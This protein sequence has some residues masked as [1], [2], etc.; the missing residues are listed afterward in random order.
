[1]GPNEHRLVV[2]KRSA[3]HFQ[4]VVENGKPQE[5]ITTLIRRMLAE[6]AQQGGPVFDV[7]ERSAGGRKEWNVIPVSARGKDGSF[8]AQAGSWITSCPF[9]TER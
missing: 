7:Q 3:F 4:Y 1:V 9:R 2:P 6:Y 5:D 8:V